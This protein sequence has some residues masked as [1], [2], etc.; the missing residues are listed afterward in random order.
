MPFDSDGNLILPKDVQME[1]ESIR[2]FRQFHFTGVVVSC[3][4]CHYEWE[5]RSRRAGRVHCY[6]CNSH[7]RVGEIE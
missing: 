3:P 4:R 5:R 6:R 1:F 7:V 2:R